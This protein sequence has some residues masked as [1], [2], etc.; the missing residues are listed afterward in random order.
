MNK[1]ELK[2]GKEIV[3]INVSRAKSVEILNEKPMN[4][5]KD[6]KE[7]FIKGVTTDMVAS[8]PLKDVINNDDKVTIV[9]SDLTRLWQR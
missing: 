1:V 6:L 7:A 2:Y 5:I 4:E 8:K 3:S 9:V